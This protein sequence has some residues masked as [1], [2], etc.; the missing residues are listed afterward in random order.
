MNTELRIFL[1]EDSPIDAELM[2]REICQS[3]CVCSVRRV[4]TREA[5]LQQLTEFVPDL[6][7]ADYRLPS[8]MVSAP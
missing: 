2:E 3:D 1:L 4:E 6:I 7:L 5:F 8:S